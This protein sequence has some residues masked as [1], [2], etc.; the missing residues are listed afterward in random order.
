MTGI[1]SKIQRLAQAR[2]VASV[3]EAISEHGDAIAAEWIHGGEVR[4]MSYRQQAE[5]ARQVAARLMQALPAA[6]GPRVVGLHLDNS[7][8][9]PVLFWG[10]LMAGFRPLL[11]DFRATPEA[12]SGA[13]RDAAAEALVTEDPLLLEQDLVAGGLLQLTRRELVAEGPG[14]EEG[15]QPRW[16]D[17]LVLCTSGTTEASRL[18]VF[19]GEQM[20]VGFEAGAAVYQESP[21]LL[22]PEGARVLAFIPYYHVFGVLI[23]YLLNAL[24]GHVHVY[25]ADRAPLTITSTCRRLGV[26]HL[27]AVP[28]LWNN[29]VAKIRT[30]VS[31]KGRRAELLFGLICRVSLGLQR[32]APQAAAR[33]FRRVVFRR[34][35]EKLFGVDLRYAVSGGA[36]IAPET[37]ALLAAVGVPISQGYGLTEAGIVSTE[38]SP[39]LKPRLGA[40]LGRA[41]CETRLVPP[42][43]GEVS[44]GVGV[45]E[46]RGEGLHAARMVAGKEHPRAVNDEG[47]YHTG[48]LVRIDAAGRIYFLGRSK[49]VIVP[50]S[51]ENVYPAELEARFEEVMPEAVDGLCV[52]GL[53][54]ARGLEEVVLLV[55]PAETHRNPEGRAAL[56]RALHRRNAAL[57][58]V[59]R[60][61]RIYALDEPLPTTT[62]MKTQ[63]RRLRQEIDEGRRLIPLED[64]GPDEAPA[65]APTPEDDGLLAETREE[66]RGHFARVLQRRVEDIPDRAHFIH[67]L[68][69]D[70]MD[71]IA[72]AA[73]IEKTYS[74]FLPDSVLARCTNLDELSREIARR[75]GGDAGGPALDADR[76]V[77]PVTTFEEAPEFKAFMDRARRM[78]FDPFF[79][80]HDSVVRDT[81][82]VGDE[83]LVN[84]ASYNY[85]GLSGHPD[86]VAAARDAV[87]NLGTSAS[88]SRLLTG[89]KTLYREL[90]AA[91]AAFKHVEDAIVLVSGHAT[92]VT[93]VGN[94][95]GPDDL[96][97]YD[98][99]S[100]N[101][102]EQGCRLSLAQCKAFPH[103]DFAALEDMLERHRHRFAKVLLVVEGV[104]SMDGDIAPVPEFVRLKKRY[105]TFLMVDEAHSMGVI[106]ATGRGVDEHFGLAPDDID[107]RMGTLSKAL[108]SCGGYL[109]GRKAMIDYL[110][111]NL[112][113]FVFSV[114]IPPA[115]AAAA[116]AAIQ[117]LERDPG[118][119]RRLHANVAHFLK[120]ARLRG[121]DT[122]LAEETAIVPIMVG[123]EEA[124]FVLCQRLREAGAFVV[125][126]VYPAVPRG[127][128]R[129]RCCVTS[130]HT[131]GQIQKFLDTL[132]RVAGGLGLVLTAPAE[133]RPR[134][135]AAA[136]RDTHDEAASPAGG[137]PSR[138]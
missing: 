60:A 46:L 39:G 37:L 21:D 90:E 8:E 92:N 19:T 135:S 71:A 47:W 123:D 4:R 48:D 125:P 102:I 101:S 45:L 122:C 76:Q 82:V 10:I 108:G 79:V 58:S 129:L 5:L 52:L 55:Y 23:V 43:G 130:E 94:F 132:E 14:P 26:T 133:G 88:G 114:G 126:A 61:S 136:P 86:V 137:P 87:T 78:P 84:F 95:C 103:N 35:H 115:S 32:V 96:I 124:A 66:L 121:F 93:F 40:S 81:S 72:L 75:R 53:P 63:R 31:E 2:S 17:A 70:S 110:R 64:Q 56:S 83:T 118:P 20:A 13:L 24:A 113:G 73:E 62:T 97:L 29:V 28:L 34:L 111:Y 131:P 128:A 51:G 33:F 69:G 89:E 80:R 50:A 9:W 109:A 107:I 116:L 18:Y 100:H 138:C 16:A 120:E 1:T 117:V 106:G 25:L 42:E 41:I 119:V 85:V 67:E 105:G 7:A 99:L 74:I 54:G 44:G 98:A 36:Y 104:Y 30:G 11:L 6:P 91:L 22:P 59:T 77:A 3:F 127:Q 57:P 38:A 112:P 134:A 49:E 27:S 68:G 65:A 12:L 15:W